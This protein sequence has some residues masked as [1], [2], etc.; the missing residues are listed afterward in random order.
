MILLDEFD[1]AEPA[2]TVTIKIDKKLIEYLVKLSEPHSE[3]SVKD[4]K[5]C[6]QPG[7]GCKDF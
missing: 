7:T 2:G 5:L 3:S 1:P 6:N 4:T